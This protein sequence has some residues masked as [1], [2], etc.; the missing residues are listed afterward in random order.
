MTIRIL[1]GILNFLP[2]IQICPKIL[3]KNF[4]QGIVTYDSI[5]Y[6]PNIL[7]NQKLLEEIT[8]HIERKETFEQISMI[9]NLTSEFIEKHKNDLDWIL[10]SGNEFISVD[11]II[12][13]KQYPWNDFWV[14]M[15]PNV[16]WEII[17]QHPEGIFCPYTETSLEGFSYNPNLTW[18]I[19][20][21]NPNIHWEWRGI[22]RNKNRSLANCFRK[23]ILFLGIGKQFQ[24]NQK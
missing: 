22:S 3:S 10:L 17:Q 21:T 1:I 8:E 14:M 9:G 16:T 6:N 18:E 23:S 2:P 12:E 11:F 13:H 15:N 19:V 4:F 20:K 24:Q 5:V 7:S